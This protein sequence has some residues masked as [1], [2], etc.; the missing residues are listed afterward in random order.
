MIKPKTYTEAIS[1]IK[2]RLDIVDVVSE[3]VILKKSG[4]N[5]MGCC[6]FH[7]EKTPSF[8]VIP[9]LGIYK[10]F[11]CGEGGDALSFIMKTKNIEF[12]DLILELAEKF[13]LEV[14]QKYNKRF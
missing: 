6:P 3:Y 5:Y 9:S 1:L 10:C 14:Q 2:E 7:K 13:E 4:R 12:K 11:G 8:S